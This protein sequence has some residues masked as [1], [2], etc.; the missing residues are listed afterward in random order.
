MVLIP[1]LYVEEETRLIKGKMKTDNFKPYLWILPSVTLL[2]TMIAIPV[3]TVFELS[4][5]DVGKTG[6]IKGFAGFEN[7][8]AVFSDSNFWQALLNTLI[9][10][11]VV[12]LLST[13]IGFLFALALNR[14][15]FGK[16]VVRAI[17]IF[18][19]ATSLT[20]QALVW[21]FILN[22]DYGALNTLLKRLGIIDGL[23]N[24]TSSA[25]ATFA[26]ECWIG[27]FVTVPFV[28]YCLLSGLQSIDSTYYEAAEVDGSTYFTKLKRITIPLLK[29]NLT[30]ST[31]LNIIYVFNSFPIIWIISK[32]GPADKTHTLVTYLY[33]L[34]F[35][36]GKTGYAASVSVI[37]FLIL[38]VFSG[39]YMI[40]TLKSENRDKK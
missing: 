29:P 25:L 8:S 16:K 37:G 35:Y 7:F 17:V 38:C 1:K 21:K 32:G 13:I 11:I 19:W 15:F 18:P 26:W 5:T 31:V 24:W 4:V 9:W 28:T 39:V 23:V 20:I 2:V 14:P 36:G 27:I 30:V 10:T 6:L 33:K 22:A 34:A 3:V 12:V 40:M